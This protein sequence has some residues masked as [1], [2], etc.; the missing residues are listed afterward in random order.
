MNNELNIKSLIASFMKNVVWL[1]I[2]PLVCACL[3]FAVSTTKKSTYT[4]RVDFISKNNTDAIDYLHT[5]P[6][7]AK[8][9]EKATYVKILTS[10][11]TLSKVSQILSTKYGVGLTVSEL[12]SILSTSNSADDASFS[13]IIT[14]D[15]PDVARK[16]TKAIAEIFVPVINETYEKE[17]IVQVLTK[18]FVE[19]ENKPDIIKPSVIAAALGFI[20]TFAVCFVLAYT[21]KTIRSEAE[22]KEKLGIPVIGVIPRWMKG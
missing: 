6:Q 21:D 2:I 3:M 7:T 20:A 11:T 8:I 9:N 15:S 12:K 14:C 22:A 4:S 18:E 13:A 17:N 16:V 19:K 5:T 1:I 10:D